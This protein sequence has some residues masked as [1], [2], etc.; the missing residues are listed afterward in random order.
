MSNSSS[1]WEVPYVMTNISCSF[2]LNT[3]EV[4]FY[5]FNVCILATCV[6]ICLLPV[7]FDKFSIRTT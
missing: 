4:E 7:S 3:S 1:I 2:H 5:F 6:S